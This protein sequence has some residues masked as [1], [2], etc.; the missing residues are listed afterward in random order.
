LFL[1]PPLSN[2]TR[3]VFFFLFCFR[4]SPLRQFPPLGFSDLKVGPLFPPLFPFFFPWEENP[5]PFCGVCVASFFPFFFPRLFFFR[6]RKRFRLFSRSFFFPFLLLLM[7]GPPPFLSPATFFS[8]KGG[9]L[10]SP[11]SSSRGISFPCPF[12]D[13]ASPLFFPTMVR[14]SFFS[15]FLKATH[16][17]SVAAFVRHVG[18]FF[19]PGR[20]L[21]FPPTSVKDRS[22]PS[23]GSLVHGLP[24]FF[25]LFPPS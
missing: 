5:P 10:P 22:P 2:I 1:F 23:C 15:P 11:L 13:K 3:L 4:S 17:F 18:W 16:F 19:L 6:E 14:L 20:R 7:T 24:F 12:E 9:V 8:L 25:F 21:P